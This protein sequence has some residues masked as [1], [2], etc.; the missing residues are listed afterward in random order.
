[1]DLPPHSRRVRPEFVAFY[2]H[3]F[4]FAWRTLRRLGVAPGEC[5]D[6]AQDVF[7]TAHQRWDTVRETD[8]R[9]A[10]LAGIARRIAW[11]YRRSRDRRE[12]KAEALH[13]LAT[14]PAGLD[15]DVARRQA[16]TRLAAFLDGLDDDRRTAFVLGELEQLGRNELGVALGINAN[17]AY[18]RL[19]SARRAFFAHF[20]ADDDG[21]ITAMLTGAALATD[22]DPSAAQRT[23]RRVVA[24]VGTPLASAGKLALAAWTTGFVVTAT[25]V[26]SFVPTTPVAEIEP[27][28]EVASVATP[29]PSA[30]AIAPAIPPTTVIVPEPIAPA[31][32]RSTPART[33]RA[34]RPVATI[35]AEVAVLVAARDALAAGDVEGAR[36]R[37]AE[38]QRSFGST[39][40]LGDLRREIEAAISSRAAGDEHR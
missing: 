8:R 34:P 40:M 26:A 27:V 35:D 38:H 23:W 20:A 19:Q 4:A 5:D 1:M 10:W 31:R 18:S 32:P 39:A 28:R 11:R 30:I 21:R 7:V 17:T 36:R 22:A 37:I 13:L 29:E 2:R 24:I 9:R 14:R 25:A 33:Q 16:W 12:R 15:D 3:E 6:A